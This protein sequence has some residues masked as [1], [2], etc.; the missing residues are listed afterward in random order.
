M[1]DPA[2]EAR[3]DDFEERLAD[4]E[5]RVR[6]VVAWLLKLAED[7]ALYAKGKK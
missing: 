1:I 4:V 7:A 3:L 6:E 5:R 2:F